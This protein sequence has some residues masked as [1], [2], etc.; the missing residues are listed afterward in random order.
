M[1]SVPSSISLAA[2]RCMISHY[3]CDSEVCTKSFT[4]CTTTVVT[5][6]EYEWSVRLQCSVCHQVWWLCSGC[7]LRKKLRHNNQLVN[8]QYGAH[9]NKG[10]SNRKRSLLMNNVNRINNI[11]TITETNSSSVPITANN[12]IIT[13]NTQTMFPVT[14]NNETITNNTQTMVTE[15]DNKDD[16]EYEDTDVAKSLLDLSIAKNIIETNEAEKSMNIMSTNDNHLDVLQLCRSTMIDIL[17]SKNQIEKTNKKTSEYYAYDIIS[18]GNKYLV[19]KMLAN[20]DGNISD[21][22]KAITNEEVKCQLNIATF[23]Q[24]L[25]RIERNT[26]VELIQEIKNVYFNPSI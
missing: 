8:H 11:A 14:A 15:N 4:V 21:I 7:A 24:S 22:F 10:S 1:N 12:E 26:F 25:S 17:E 18:S 19:T 16:N 13:N 23:I 6:E 2:P 20:E 3:F 9:G 5:Q